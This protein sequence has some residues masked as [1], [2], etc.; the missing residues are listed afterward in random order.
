MDLFE[1][2]NFLKKE[3]KA[4]YHFTKSYNGM[5][6]QIERVANEPV[7]IWGQITSWIY[8]KIFG[9]VDISK[10]GGDNGKKMNDFEKY[11]S[12]NA[13]DKIEGHFKKFSDDSL[14]Q[15]EIENEVKRK[16]L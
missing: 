2:E 5:T 13:F 14:S 1:K 3:H 10:D 16:K 4:D 6:K 8:L 12:S 11:Q 15:D 7:T 9:T